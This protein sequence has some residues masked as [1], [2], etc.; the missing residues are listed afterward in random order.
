MVT[1]ISSEA[2]KKSWMDK[3]TL[4]FYGYI[5]SK[6]TRFILLQGIINQNFSAYHK[7]QSRKITYRRSSDTLCTDGCIIM[8]YRV[9][10]PLKKTK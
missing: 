2:S 5:E 3:R 8:Y 1:S 10:L 6:F 4:S 9:A 7:C